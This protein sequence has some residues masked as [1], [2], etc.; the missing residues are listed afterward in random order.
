M[1][2][3]GFRSSIAN[4]KKKPEAKTQYISGMKTNSV[5]QMTPVDALS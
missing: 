1:R 2:K 4:E 5:E 3:F